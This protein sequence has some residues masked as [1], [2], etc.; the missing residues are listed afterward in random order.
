MHARR[1]TP[2]GLL[3]ALLA[4]AAVLVAWPSPQ[5]LSGTSPH[6]PRPAA[7]RE[8]G[9]SI[10]GLKLASDIHQLAARHYE[11]TAS[12][13]LAFVTVRNRDTL[14]SIAQRVY[15]NP[16]AWTVLYYGNHRPDPFGLKA[17]SVLRV[18]PLPRHIPAPPG[19]AASVTTASVTSV[20][21]PHSA[22]P[23]GSLQS[24]ALKLLGGSQVQFSCLDSVIMVESSWNIYASNGSGAYGIPQALPGSKMA[25]AGADWATDGYTQLRWMINDYIAGSYQGSACNAWA[26]E[27]ADGWY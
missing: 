14:T 27:Q 5:A 7:I 6:H 10:P 16:A 12:A 21:A 19:P 23:V 25:A 11:A 2:Y 17:G 3:T 1:R 18:P 24:Y 8:L 26:H 9:S 4:C 20:S 13:Q 15:G 22:T